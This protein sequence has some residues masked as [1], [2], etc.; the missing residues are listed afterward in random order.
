[1][2]LNVDQIRIVESKPNGHVLIKGVAGSGKTT[3]AVSK[4]P[5]LVNHY[6][7][8]NDEI[9]FVT[10]NKTLIEY[11]KKLTKNTDFK[12]QIFFESDINKKLNIKTIDSIITY[13][14]S[15]L[16]PKRS[17]PTTT[18]MK[19]AMRKAIR[20]V[21]TKYEKSELISEKY[22]AF[23][24][25]EIDW[26]K[27]CGY[28]ERETYLNI[29]RIG[30]MSKGENRYRLLKNSEERKAIFDIYLCYEKIMEQERLIDFKTNALRVLQAFREGKLKPKSYRHVIV[31]ESQD[32]TRIQLEIIRFLYQEEKENASI[33]FIADVTQSI[34]T[35]SWLSGQSFKSVGFDMSGK[36]NIL[37]KNYR[38]T[39]EIAQAAYS[40]IENDDA[41]KQNDNFVKPVAIERH[42]RAPYYKHYQNVVQEAEGIAKRIKQL[43]TRYPLKDIVVVAANSV[44]LNHIKDVFMKKG[45]PAEIFS[46]TE[47]DFD[48]DVVRLFTLH[49]VKGLE[50]PVLFIACVN[51][52]VL[53]YAQEDVSVGRR[54]LYVGMTRAKQELYLSSSNKE[55]IFIH[56]LDM[57]L[58]CSD[59]TEF[60]SLYK[61]DISEYLFTDKL[62]DIYSKEEMVRQW[63]MKELI[64][65]K[66][67]PKENLDIEYPVQRFSEKG[68]VDVVVFGDKNGQKVPYI[69]AE[70]KQ[71][72]EDMDR[73]QKQLRSYADCCPFVEYIVTTDGK[74]MMMEKI[75]NKQ[76]ETIESLPMYKPQEHNIY[77]TYEY[78]VYDSKRKYRYEINCEDR[79]EI[80]IKDGDTKEVLDC[81]GHRPVNVI[82]EV[83]AGVLKYAYEEK[84]GVYKFPNWFISGND[85]VFMLEVHGDSMINFN[86]NE[87]DFVLVRKQNYAKNGDIVVAGQRGSNEVTLKQYCNYGGNVGLMPGNPKYE[88]IM[89]PED[90]LFVN[91][92]LVG[93]LK[94]QN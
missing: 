38:T 56:E 75:V 22:Y 84:L 14:G 8:Q 53:P 49:S 59:D 31:D 34:Y 43:I 51:E 55:S 44:C 69:L 30:R 72:G 29:D 67:Y 5:M 54:L 77:D 80:V 60:A 81:N 36:S 35:Q 66:Q 79:E 45:I 20:Y 42:G 1:M 18:Q 64:V 3:I 11:T 17:L 2:E 89:I 19:N 73:A 78:I 62:H 91:G 12:E 74:E 15:R 63:F 25:E 39:Y 9:L 37:S 71:T 85:E 6:M 82:G 50:F 92:V 90:E 70:I 16:E 83:A 68:Y 7:Q 10:Y 21:Q 87:G 93:I 13:Y 40:L 4:I 27:S 58:L 23:L 48:E 61:V 86:I 88:P 76:Y 33:M 57:G 52:G 24:N 94:H 32:L 47:P 41:I 28:I 46:K 26:L 65:K